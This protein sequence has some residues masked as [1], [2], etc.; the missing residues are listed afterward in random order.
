MGRQCRRRSSRAAA[1]LESEDALVELADPAV[2]DEGEEQRQRDRGE[3]GGEK[4][5]R[6][7]APSRRR[8]GEERR[9]GGRGELTAAATAVVAPLIVERA[10]AIRV[11]TR[12]KATS[13]SLKL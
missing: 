10:T 4:D 9:D 11:I 5:R 1:R 2:G 12:R 8:R 13:A 6:P 3:R 7:E